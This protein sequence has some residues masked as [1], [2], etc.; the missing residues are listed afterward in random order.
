MSCKNCDQE[1]EHG[2]VTYMRLGKANIGV[3]VCPFHFRLLRHLIVDNSDYIQDWEDNEG[4][5]TL[6]GEGHGIS[7]AEM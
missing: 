1:E 6:E 7:R 4:V 5:V 3:F 2:R